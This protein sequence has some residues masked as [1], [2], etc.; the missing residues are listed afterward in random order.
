M[1]TERQCVAYVVPSANKGGCITTIRVA[2]LRR[3]RD[4]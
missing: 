2:R 1:T 4:P 3:G